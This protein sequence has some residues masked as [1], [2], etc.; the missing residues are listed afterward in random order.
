V[1][2]FNPD[3]KAVVSYS[4]YI[5]KPDDKLVNYWPGSY[6]IRPSAAFYTDKYLAFVS[7][8]DRL[9]ELLQT[10]EYYILTD[11]T[12]WPEVAQTG[13]RDIVYQRGSYMLAHST[14]KPR[15]ERGVE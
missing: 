2:D 5:L 4:N 3:V 1:G 15:T 11:A 7:D 10:G 13:Y 8:R 14:P 12:F 9:S 6:W